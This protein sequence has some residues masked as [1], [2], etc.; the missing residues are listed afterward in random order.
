MHNGFVLP[1]TLTDLWAIRRVSLA[2]QDMLTLPEHLV[3]LLVFM[4]VRIVQ[5]LVFSVVFLY[6]PMF[7]LVSSCFIWYCLPL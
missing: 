5:A 7:V 1:P 2:K 4:R 3:S 6:V